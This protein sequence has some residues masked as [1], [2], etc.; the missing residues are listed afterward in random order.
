[1]QIRGAH[2][3]PTTNCEETPPPKKTQSV[4]TAQLIVNVVYLLP[5]VAGM[6]CDLPEN[7]QSLEIPDEDE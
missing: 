7:V 3:V 5:Q 4:K 2:L 6:R 1:M